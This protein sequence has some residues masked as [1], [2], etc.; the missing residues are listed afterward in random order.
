MKIKKKFVKFILYLLIAYLIAFPFI[1]F[2]IGNYIQILIATFFAISIW[3]LN[4]L[5]EDKEFFTLF[6]S[7]FG[8]AYIIGWSSIQPAMN[9]ILNL[10]G[11]ENFDLFLGL[12]LTH[13]LFVVLV[14]IVGL[15]TLEIHKL[16]KKI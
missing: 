2:S 8:T 15:I 5:F 11:F 16:I 3:F 6:G 9:N 7:T 13:L 10:I 1:G 4:F 12:Q 14:I